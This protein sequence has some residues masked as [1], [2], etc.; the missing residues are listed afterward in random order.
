[1]D[2]I[3]TNIVPIGAATI[4]GLAVLWLGFRT[5]VCGRTIAIAD[6][7]LFWLAAI[8]AGALI[9][10]PVQ[11]GAWTIA[12]GTAFIIWIGFVLPALSVALPLRGTT[13]ARA[14]ADAGWWLAIMLAQA[15]VLHGVGLTKPAGG[16]GADTRAVT[17][18]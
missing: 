2:Y 12:L 11:A 15:A 6:P 18:T 8:L 10:A 3:L 13:P 4:A 1:M 17:P 16:A 14:L 9:L 5:R 7:A